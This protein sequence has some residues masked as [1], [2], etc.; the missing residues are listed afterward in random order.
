[1]EITNEENRITWR[2]LITLLLLVLFYKSSNPLDLSW[3]QG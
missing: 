2:S 3:W 1:V